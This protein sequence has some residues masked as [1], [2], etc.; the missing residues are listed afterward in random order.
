MPIVKV[1]A[2]AEQIQRAARFIFGV[3]VAQDEIP[4][5]DAAFELIRT[6]VALAARAQAPYGKAVAALVGGELVGVAL[7]QADGTLAYLEA[8][9]KTQAVLD[10]LAAGVVDPDPF[11][12]LS[13]ADKIADLHARV[14]VL[15]GRS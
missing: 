10:A 15:E 1:P 5:S 12:S 9:T 7:I 14:K 4:R 13:P 2:N 3:K 11:D 6:Q 8:T